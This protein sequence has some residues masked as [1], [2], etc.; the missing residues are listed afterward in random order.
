MVSHI[1]NSSSSKGTSPVEVLMT[2]TTFFLKGNQGS[3]NINSCPLWQS[4]RLRRVSGPRLTF[5]SAPHVPL[6]VLSQ[7]SWFQSTPSFHCKGKAVWNAWTQER[8]SSNFTRESLT[9][10]CLR[11]QNSDLVWGPRVISFED[12]F[13]LCKYS[14]MGG[15]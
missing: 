2:M 12:I 13:F 11:V 14:V 4:W 3:K 7:H 9:Y 6:A 5:P 1:S 15:L 10:K 8:Q